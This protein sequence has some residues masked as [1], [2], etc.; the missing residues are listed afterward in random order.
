MMNQEKAAYNVPMSR[1]LVRHEEELEAL[2]ER[3]SRLEMWIGELLQ[4]DTETAV[5]PHV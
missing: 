2:R 5:M 3:V 1:R 4:L